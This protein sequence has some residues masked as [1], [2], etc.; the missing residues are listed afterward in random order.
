MDQALQ[1][2]ADTGVALRR[3]M[4]GLGVTDRELAASLRHGVLRRVRQ[5]AYTTPI[6]GTRSRTSPATS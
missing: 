6:G 3:E 4:I 2:I 5:G 1:L